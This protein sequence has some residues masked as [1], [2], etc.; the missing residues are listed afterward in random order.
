MMSITMTG[1]LICHARRVREHYNSYSSIGKSN[2]ARGRET[3][4]WLR[5]ERWPSILPSRPLSPHDNG[6]I[7]SQIMRCVSQFFR[8]G[9][10]L[11]NDSQQNDIS[12][13]PISALIPQQQNTAQSFSPFGRLLARWRVYGAFLKNVSE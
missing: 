3:N 6:V 8:R 12:I 4:N 10:W 5:K 13:N 9:S 2:F 1:F 7:P 11:S